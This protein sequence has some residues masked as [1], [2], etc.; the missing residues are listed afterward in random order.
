MGRRLLR[1]RDKII[2]GVCGG[3]AEYF[4]ISTP[5]VRAGFLLLILLQGLGFIV[6]LVLLLVL[7][8]PEAVASAPGT[9]PYTGPAATPSRSIL[10][11]M[12]GLVVTVVGAVV[13]LVGFAADITGIAEFLKSDAEDAPAVPRRELVGSMDVRTP[14]RSQPDEGPTMTPRPASFPHDEDLRPLV[15]E[16]A[17]SMRVEWTMGPYRYVATLQL[18]GD[19]GTA[20]VDYAEGTIVQDLQRA[21]LPGGVAAL[22]GSNVR[23]IAGTAPYAPDV[24]VLGSS[25]L[26]PG[27][28]I[29]TLACDVLTD[30]CVPLRVLGELATGSPSGYVER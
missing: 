13:S 7:P 14:S 23:V 3:L 30:T 12:T 15:A 20:R 16:S 1:S 19:R 10:V 25:P 6:Y 18:Q 26:V 8:P 11:R 28:L 29:F 5:L 21:Q 4:H 9:E 24:F 22:V 2:A 17:R 27:E